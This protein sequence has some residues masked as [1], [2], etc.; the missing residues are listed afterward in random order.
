MGLAIQSTEPQVDALDFLKRAISTID[1]QSSD[2][3][4]V[5][6]LGRV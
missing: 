6:Y 4:R 3:S 2:L 5:R 1:Y